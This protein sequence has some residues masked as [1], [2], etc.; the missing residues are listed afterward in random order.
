MHS[1]AFSPPTG[2]D[3]V[4]NDDVKRKHYG[5]KRYGIQD[6][7]YILCS[8]VHETHWKYGNVR[9]AI[10]GVSNIQWTIWIKIAKRNNTPKHENSE[11]TKK[12]Q[13]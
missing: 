13:W 2:K 5:T 1:R 7:K 12:N 8:I 4:A 3:L 10:F 6:N 9:K 11:Y